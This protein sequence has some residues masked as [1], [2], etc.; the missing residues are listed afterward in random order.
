MT[1]TDGEPLGDPNFHDGNITGIVI[2]TERTLLLNC[3]TISGNKYVLRLHK[4][5]RLRAD[6]FLE[7]NIIFGLYI[8]T[9]DFPLALVATAYGAASDDTPAWLVERVSAMQRD[10][11][12]LLAIESSLGC[13]LVAVAQGPMEIVQV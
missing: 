6:E 4:L 2:D 11:W 7:G 8:Y 13:R 1:T 10:K 12:L 3:T 9:H 5:E